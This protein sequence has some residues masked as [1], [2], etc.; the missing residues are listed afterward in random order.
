MKLLKN[1]VITLAF[2]SF[3]SVLQASYVQLED[4]NFSGYVTD[5][6]IA[7]DWLDYFKGVDIQAG[8]RFDADFELYDIGEGDGT[9]SSFTEYT[10]YGNS[11]NYTFSVPADPFDWGQTYLDGNGTLIVSYHNNFSSDGLEAT[12]FDYSSDSGHFDLELKDYDKP[13]INGHGNFGWEGADIS[14]LVEPVAQ[15]NEPSVFVTLG[16]GLL[17]ISMRLKRAKLSVQA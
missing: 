7:A 5:I 9:L 10:F 2:Y 4:R 13:G 15:V 1:T 12:F 16:L 11:R 14:F 17:L 3:S 8:S 6:K